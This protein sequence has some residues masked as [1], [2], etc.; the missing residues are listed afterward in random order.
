MHWGAW[1]YD[2]MFLYLQKCSVHI[3]T[4]DFRYF[5]TVCIEH[6]LDV[7]TDRQTTGSTQVLALILFCSFCILRYPKHTSPFLFP[8]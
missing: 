1:P 5:G 4:Y 8:L 3:T 7:H 2:S 6:A